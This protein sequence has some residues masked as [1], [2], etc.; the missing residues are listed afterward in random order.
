MAETIKQKADAA[1][2]KIAETAT[3]V[4]HKVSEKVEEVTDWA[5]Q[6][7]HQVGHRVDEIAQKAEHKAKET[8]G[9][10]ALSQ[11]SLG[12]GGFCEIVETAWHKEVCHAKEVY[13]SPHG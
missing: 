4:G 13:R 7:A 12:V 6:K 5:K 10:S 1:S 11:V 3:T 9:T 8:F 2:H